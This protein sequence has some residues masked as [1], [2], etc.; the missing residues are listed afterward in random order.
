MEKII[1]LR[2]LIGHKSYIFIRSGGLYLAITCSMLIP[3]KWV[4]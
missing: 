2:K 1:K 4:S 3:K